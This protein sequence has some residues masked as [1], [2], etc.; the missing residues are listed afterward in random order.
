MRVFI[1]TDRFS[2]DPQIGALFCAK[3]S[4]RNNINYPKQINDVENGGPI[5]GTKLSVFL[6]KNARDV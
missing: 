1:C 6:D 5:W 3:L 4:T 2:E